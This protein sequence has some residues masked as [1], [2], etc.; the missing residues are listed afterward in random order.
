MPSEEE[1]E[2]AYRAFDVL[3]TDGTKIVASDIV[4]TILEAAEEERAQKATDQHNK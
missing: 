3:M 1:I 4:A 2:A